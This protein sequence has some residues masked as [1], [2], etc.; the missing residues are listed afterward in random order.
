VTLPVLPP[1]EAIRDL[2]RDLIETFG[3]SPGIRD[4][5]LLEQS[6]AR[7]LQVIAYAGDTVTV[8][9]VAV[10]LCASLNRNHPFVDGNKRI[11]FTALGIT[12]A[13]NGYDLD[14]TERE[15]TATMMAVSA[16]ELSEDQLRDW[17]ARNSIPRQTQPDEAP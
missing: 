7:P 16:G 9:D 13:L 14:V 6:L 11:T 5:G 8:I 4:H 3:G 12:L 10:A 15:A 1:L 17:V 2:H